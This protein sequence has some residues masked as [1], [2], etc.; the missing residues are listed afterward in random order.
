M[1]P[2][3]H[4]GMSHIAGAEMKSLNAPRKKPL[5]DEERRVLKEHWEWGGGWA[6]IWIIFTLLIFGGAHFLFDTMGFD[7]RIRIPAYIMLAT[8]VLVNAIWR[9]AGALAARIELATR[10][11]RP[12]GQQGIQSPKRE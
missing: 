4:R 11:N 12:D 3:D 10:E 6:M 7:D 1:R 5:S 2:D 8:L 9:A